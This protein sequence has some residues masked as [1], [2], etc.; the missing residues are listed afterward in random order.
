MQRGWRHKDKRK[1]NIARIKTLKPEAFVKSW[2]QVLLVLRD[3]YCH[4]IGSGSTFK[5]L[6]EMSLVSPQ[7]RVTQPWGI[8]FLDLSCIGLRIRALNTCVSSWAQAGTP[9]ILVSHPELEPGPC[10]YLCLILSSSRDPTNTC[11]SSWARAGTPQILVSHLELEPGP[12][13]YLCLILSSSRDP[14]SPIRTWVNNSLLL[15]NLIAQTKNNL[16]HFG[17]GTFSYAWFLGKDFSNF[18]VD[19]E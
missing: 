16:V 4:F 12:C 14:D 5:M 13:K 18:T 6:Y 1:L 19:I 9:Q 7:A 17:H 15:I 2:F 10:K 3:I 11:V 8:P